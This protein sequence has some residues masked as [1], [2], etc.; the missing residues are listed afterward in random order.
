MEDSDAFATNTR[1][2][3]MDVVAVTRAMPGRQTFTSVCFLSDSM[4]MLRT[5]ENG[6]FW[7]WSLWRGQSWKL[8]NIGPKSRISFFKILAK[9]LWAFWLACWH[10]Y[11][12]KVLINGPA[13]HSAIPQVCKWF[14]WIKWPWN[15]CLNIKSKEHWRK[16]KENST[17][18]MLLSVMLRDILK[19]RSEQLISN[20][21]N[22]IM[23][24]RNV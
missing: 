5:I 15:S 19:R 18:D 9:Q 2:L 10:G 16:L 21:D 7:S 20:E 1:G 3:I 17:P 4:R 8:F 13:W 6:W 12:E 22:L 24:R 23:K 11:C 14:K